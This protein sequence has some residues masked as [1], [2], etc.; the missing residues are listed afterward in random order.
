MKDQSNQDSNGGVGRRKEEVVG[1]G[2]SRT[3]E[4]G[5]GDGEWTDRVIIIADGG[6]P[7]ATYAT[8]ETCN[9]I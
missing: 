5:V 3:K 4:R 6:L 2:T 8:Y 9:Y 7:K 1:V